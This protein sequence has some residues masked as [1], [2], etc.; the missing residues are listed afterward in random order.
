M[1]DA[2][3]SLAKCLP[4]LNKFPLGFMPKMHAENARVAQGSS[5]INYFGTK[6]PY[7]CD[8]RTGQ[9]AGTP[10][11]GREDFAKAIGAYV[12]PMIGGDSSW[13]QQTFGV[14]QLI[15]YLVPSEG[16]PKPN[17]LNIAQQSILGLNSANAALPSAAGGLASNANSSSVMCCHGGNGTQTGGSC[18][19]DPGDPKLNMMET[20]ALIARTVQQSGHGCLPKVGRQ[21]WKSDDAFVAD[22]LGA[23]VSVEIPV[24][25]ETET[26]VLRPMRFGMACRG[27]VLDVR[28]SEQFPFGGGAKAP[29][30]EN[31]AD[32]VLDAEDECGGKVIVI[33]RCGAKPGDK[34]APTCLGVVT[35]CNSEKGF[36]D[37]AVTHVGTLYDACMFNSGSGVVLNRRI[38]QQGELPDFVESVLDK[39]NIPKGCEVAA[40]HNGEC[41]V[42]SNIWNSEMKVYSFDE[43]AYIHTGDSGE[44]KIGKAETAP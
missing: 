8:D 18:P 32:A 39:L 11:G 22:F 7:L 36:I 23:T 44:H 15:S 3:E 34:P 29:K 35:S 28:S 12:T 14:S 9:P 37:I 24:D 4:N 40:V 19:V 5:F 21:W 16:K 1:A 6:R 33:P 20:Y 17:G 38:W 13:A 41:E 27:S 26:G 10:P 25:G 43:D 2:C 42:A 31:G 30:I